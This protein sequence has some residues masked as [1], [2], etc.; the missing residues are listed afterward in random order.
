MLPWQQLMGILN[1]YKCKYKT[2]PHDYVKY[3]MPTNKADK[4]QYI[5][6]LIHCK[7]HTQLHK[8]YTSPCNAHHLT[9]HVVPLTSKG[10]LTGKPSI[11][12]HT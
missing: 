8:V 1:K 12:S 3:V 10:L 7:R 4:I 11:I 6:I 9:W 5:K 2:N